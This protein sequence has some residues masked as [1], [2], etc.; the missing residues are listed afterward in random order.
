VR[1]SSFL[2]GDHGTSGHTRPGDRFGAS[3]ATLADRDGDAR[4]ELGVGAPGDDD[5][6][7]DAGAIWLLGPRAGTS[8]R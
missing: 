5:G 8:G 1:W 2:P 4:V 7:P 6:E 3:L